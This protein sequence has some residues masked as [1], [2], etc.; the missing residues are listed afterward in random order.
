MDV[1]SDQTFLVMTKNYQ[2]VGVS[3]A[4]QRI[5]KV[6]TWATPL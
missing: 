2:Q 5:A 1:D 4:S 6:S 3:L